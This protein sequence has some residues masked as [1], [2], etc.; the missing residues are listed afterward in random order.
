M[1]TSL[2]ML[3]FEISNKNSM[4][5]AKTLQSKLFAYSLRIRLDGQ[6]ALRRIENNGGLNVMDIYSV[7]ISRTYS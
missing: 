2:I 1:D 4:K 5:H 7:F 3:A 6:E